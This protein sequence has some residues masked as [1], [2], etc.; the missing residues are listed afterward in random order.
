M[1][2][3]SPSQFVAL[4]AT[5]ATASLLILSLLMMDAGVMGSSSVTIRE[6]N[7]TRSSFGATAGNVLTAK[8]VQELKKVSGAVVSPDG[9]FSVY[10]VKQWVSSYW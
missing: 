5:V 2:E 6:N 4:L 1:Q 8:D 7:N 10:S 9:R 3:R